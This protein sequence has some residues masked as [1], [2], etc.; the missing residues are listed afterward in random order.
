MGWRLI[1]EDGVG[2]AAGL[3]ADEVLTRRAAQ[4]AAPTLRLYTYRPH[5]AL[6]GRF[7]DAAHE[8][9]LDYCERHDIEVNRRPTGGGAILMGPDQL[10]IALAMP[11]RGAGLRAR[12]LMA[13]FS[14][15]LV[16]A[17]HD[18]GIDARF[19][20]KNDLEVGGR[21]IA[22]LGIHRE[23][24]GGLL[25][26]A[27]LLVDLDVALM[28]R[29]L[30]T[31][32]TEITE[33]ELETVAARTSTV[34]A[35]LRDEISLDEVRTRVATGFGASF[36]VELEPGRLEADE[37]A[38]IATL[39]ADR[40]GRED[41]IFQRTDVPD[42]SGRATL[43]TT[44]GLLDVQVAL[45]GPTIVALHVRGDFFESEAAVADLEGRLRWH[46]GAR[47]AVAATVRA[48]AQANPEH[49]LAPDALA[50]VIDRAV[51]VGRGDTGEPYGCFVTPE[52]THG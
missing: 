25:F 1:I 28:A 52:S 11:G 22:G 39:V 44:G 12:E 30:K 29:V 15:G 26:H 33:A 47:D 37:R 10:G 24:S 48:W 23:A 46:P 5:A 50:S 49:S 42:R 31:P 14:E 35:L 13:R 45:A 2:A 6:I 32:F 20:G 4:S 16:R 36:E 3:A 17:L 21:K 19:R 34:R 18:L 43:R 9:H 38:D 41:W 27:S 8:V 7:Q 40:Y 51:A